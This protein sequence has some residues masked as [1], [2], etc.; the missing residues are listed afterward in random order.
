M[1]GQSRLPRVRVRRSAALLTAALAGIAA[2]ALVGIAV[3]K[4]FTLRTASNETV[5]S[6][7]GTVHEGVVVNSHGAA[8]YTL[9]GDTVHHP[10]CTKAS[11]CFQFWPPVKVASAK[12]LSKAPG[13]KGKL[14]VL[15]RNGFTQVT[16]G[17]HPLYTYSGDHHR[18]TA[19]G[20]GIN[21]FGGI[22]HVSRTSAP[23]E[24]GSGTGA[25]STPTTSTNPYP[26]T[27]TTMP[28]PNPYP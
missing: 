22:W 4:S 24:G 15:R 17:G 9:S 6:A 18:G 23:K 14:G 7:T 25:T 5:A 20:E 3:A 2:A 10:K 11:G 27:T 13:I 1:N 8:V 12:K 16:L 21:T 26:S 28:Y 19:T